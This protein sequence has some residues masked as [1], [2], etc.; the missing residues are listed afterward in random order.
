MGRWWRYKWSTFQPSLTSA[1]G[2]RHQ[3]GQSS[4]D[5][6]LHRRGSGRVAVKERN[7]RWCSDGGGL[8]CGNVE[9][10]R[11]TFELEGCNREALLWAVT[12]GGFDSETVEG[13][14]LGWKAASAAAFQ[15]RFLISLEERS[16][17]QTIGA[18]CL[19][20]RK[21]NDSR[22]PEI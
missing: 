17:A 21:P 20:V 3:F 6:P 11:I 14:M 7:Q 16:Y 1:R 9:K 8:R 4:Q 19:L 2:L 10:L 15:R 18:I 5:I 13:V 12:M 22:C